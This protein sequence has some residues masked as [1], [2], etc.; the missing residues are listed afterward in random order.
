MQ[1]RWS[2]A[3][4]KSKSK[5]NHSKNGVHQLL[6]EWTQSRHPSSSGK[7]GSSRT[8]VDLRRKFARYDVN[9]VGLIYLSEFKALL[10]ELGV[11][12]TFERIAQYCE[13]YNIEPSATSRVISYEEFEEWW[14]IGRKSMTFVLQRT[15][16]DSSGTGNN[17]E[18]PHQDSVVCYRGQDTT[19]TVSGLQPNR[20]YQFRLR[21]VGSTSHSALSRP[22][23]ILTCPS[24]PLTLGT[25]YVGL[26]ELVLRCYGGQNGAER[27]RIEAKV[28]SELKSS[29][30]GTTRSSSSSLRN[31]SWQVVSSD[32]SDDD[33][34]GSLAILKNLC[35]DTTYELRLQALNYEQR[36]SGYTQVTQI[37]TQTKSEYVAL[38]PKR[39]SEGFTIECRGDVVTGDTIVFTEAILHGSDKT[40]IGDRT[41]AGRVLGRKDASVKIHI[42]WCVV[43]LLDDDDS[44][45]SREHQLIRDAVTYRSDKHLRRHELFRTPWV[46][47]SARYRSSWIKVQHMSSLVDEP[48]CIEF[49]ADEDNVEEDSDEDIVLA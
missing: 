1:L 39:A 38:T 31:D 48:E 28:V 3:A 9:D 7:S 26:N 22:L 30:K 15:V 41:I 19:T 17:N 36:A 2:S 21:Q 37:S 35:P 25:V 29:T 24:T 33:D 42:L 13:E 47:E 34:H 23:S 10:E 16:D 45:S 14:S 18:P 20:L 5:S 46:H 40:E 44:R 49:D 27:Y 12:P 4:G 43:E 8:T 32:P 6:E 11:P